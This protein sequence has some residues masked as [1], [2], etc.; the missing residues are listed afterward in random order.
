MGLEL[1]RDR[2]AVAPSA[3][4]IRPTGDAEALGTEPGAAV[5]SRVNR[6]EPAVAPVA[7]PTGE[8][9]RCDCDD[10]GARRNE[11]GFSEHRDRHPN[12]PRYR[13]ATTSAMP[14]RT[15]AT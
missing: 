10:R 9:D 4:H 5:G 12:P 11:K 1:D 2:T 8:P 15:S 14:I 6:H 3:D 7:R 13:A